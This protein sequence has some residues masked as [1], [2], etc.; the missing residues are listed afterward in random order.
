MEAYR[1]FVVHSHSVAPQK[2]AVGGIS[3]TRIP[4]NSSQ[5]VAENDTNAADDIWAIDNPV[6]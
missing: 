2:I 3:I 6:G 4:L 5:N 1:G